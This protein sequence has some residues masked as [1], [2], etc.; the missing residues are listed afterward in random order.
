MDL[1][2][3]V[4]TVR[5]LRVQVMLRTGGFLRS[6]TMGHAVTGQTKLC[7]AA[8]VQQT[9]IRR[10]VRRMTGDAAIGLYWSVLVN[11]RSLLVCVTLN[12]GC[13]RAGGEP[14]LL[15]LEAAMRIVAIAAFQRAFQH[16]MMERQ[17]EL[18]FNLAMTAQT[19][20]R[21]AGG[22]QL[23]TRDAGLLRVCR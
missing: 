5:V 23:Q 14:R 9:W 18:V 4:R 1:D 22:E 10:T 21:F 3:T 15:Q 12:A 16:F 2:V 17:L 6:D 8:R 19:E 7:D 11:K 20:L 13:I